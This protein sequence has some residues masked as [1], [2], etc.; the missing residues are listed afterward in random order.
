MSE[1]ESI[2]V[3][4][5]EDKTDNVSSLSL[6]D[7]PERNL[8]NHT[9]IGSASARSESNGMIHSINGYTKLL[10]DKDDKIIYAQLEWPHLGKTTRIK[11]PQMLSFMN[12]LFSMSEDSNFTKVPLGEQ[13]R[14]CTLPSEFNKDTL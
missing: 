8:W 1:I 13:H 6:N 4:T 7:V 10:F 11:D 14:D 9:A 5:I 12:Q 2:Q 3:D